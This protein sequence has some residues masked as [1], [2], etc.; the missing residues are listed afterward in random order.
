MIILDF[1]NEMEGFYLVND[2]T[3]REAG[4]SNAALSYQ[5]SNNNRSHFFYSHLQPQPNG[6][7][8]ASFKIDMSLDLMNYTAICVSAQSISP[9]DAVYQLI[10]DTED[11]EQLGFTYQHDFIAKANSA[12][13]ANLPFAEFY[14]SRRG[15]Q[16]LNA[17][18]MH[19][20]TIKSLGIRIVGRAGEE[21]HI[22]QSG[23]YAIQ[24]FSIAAKG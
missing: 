13:N 21:K 5:D 19:V 8:F 16:V 4:L 24:L 6:A 20:K 14:A 1:T 15:E 22:R 7:A 2:A 17:P 18:P 11:S 12:L 23:L 10:I 3:E 9:R